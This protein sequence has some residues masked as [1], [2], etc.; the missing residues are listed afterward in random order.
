[1]AEIRAFKAEEPSRGCLI[2]AQ[3]LPDEMDGRQQQAKAQRVLRKLGH[4]NCTAQLADGRICRD[5]G[6]FEVQA[7]E[8]TTIKGV[9]FEGERGS[10][11][12]L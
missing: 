6:S 12:T 8:T 3:R 4:H 2:V 1:M 5:A 10:C 7:Q 9:T 11:M